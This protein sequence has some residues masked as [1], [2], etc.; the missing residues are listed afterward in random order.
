MKQQRG[1]T[2]EGRRCE[3]CGAKTRYRT[4]QNC[5]GCNRTRNAS[6]VWS[7]PLSTNLRVLARQP[8]AHPFDREVRR[9]SDDTGGAASYYRGAFFDRC[10]L[11]GKPGLV[12]GIVCERC[13]PLV[14]A[15][16]PEAHFREP[17]ITD[18]VRR[19]A[20]LRT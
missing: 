13:A 1:A 18:V 19:L 7:G 16:A 20:E 5:R 11:C 14:N 17:D 4:S 6:R 12:D 9:K 10:E 8:D 15:P 2:Y 3:R